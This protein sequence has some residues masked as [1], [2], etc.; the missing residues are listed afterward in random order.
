MRLTVLNRITCVLLLTAIIGMVTS[1]YWGVQQLKLPFQMNRQYFSLVESI[2]VTTRG[3]I[4]NYLSTGNLSDLA[5]A[6][7]YMAQ[8]VPQSL[9]R[10]PQVVQREVLPGVEQLQQSMQQKL[11]AAGKLAGD[12]Q[13]LVVQNER[14]S[15]ALLESI[16][17]YISA[18]ATAQNREKV[19]SLQQLSLKIGQSI[20]HRILIRDKY[21]RTNTVA[22]QQTIEALSKAI[23]QDTCVY[24]SCRCWE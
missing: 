23:H 9:S 11:L 4:E 16:N 13:G 7:D 5:A 19:A 6:R 8:Q 18:G 2:S 3:L 20:S 24:N 1:V 14:E 10:L 12:M 21:F 15:L 17:E 22:L